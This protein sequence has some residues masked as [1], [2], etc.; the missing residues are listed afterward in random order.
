MR[1]FQLVAAE[2]V[3]PRMLEAWR[4]EV[5]EICALGSGANR[6]GDRG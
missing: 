3:D 6:G 2:F 1:R 5:C 4:S